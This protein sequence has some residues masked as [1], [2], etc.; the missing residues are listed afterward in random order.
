MARRLLSLTR[1]DALLLLVCII[2][3]SNF[4]VIKTAFREIEPVAFNALRL[5]IASASFLGVIVFVERRPPASGSAA[6]RWWSILRTDAPLSRGDWLNLALIGAIGHF[7]YQLCFVGSLARTTVANTSLILG[8]TPASVALASAAI[9]QERVTRHHW[10]GLALSIA[11]LYLVVG[12]GAQVSR[13]ALAGDGLAALSVLCWTIY[14]LV[15][16]R[17]MERHSPLG[18]TGLSMAMGTIPYVVLA[19]P[20]LGRTDWGAVSAQTWGALLFSAMLALCVAYLVWYVAVRQIGSTRTSVYSNV[21]P[22]VAMAVAFVWLGEP[23][24]WA[25][26][27]GA[28]AVLAGVAITRL[29][30]LPFLIPAEE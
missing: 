6:L 7:C 1:L 14:T 15:G 13:S 4:T 21:I 16:Q 29:E 28:A 30:R 9:G 20:A 2:W 8:L 22:L 24:G 10:I 17:L 23:I 26:I 3:G 18:V 25:K 19:L 5:L 11:G 12:R 27:A